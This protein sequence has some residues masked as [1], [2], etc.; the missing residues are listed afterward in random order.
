MI[1]IASNES[2]RTLRYHAL[3]FAV[4]F[5]PISA[6]ALCIFGL[7]TLPLGTVCFTLPLILIGVLIADRNPE[8][9]RNAAKG[10]CCGVIA[11][12]IYDL[13][14]W[15]LSAHLG[16]VDFIREHP[17]FPV[18]AGAALVLAR[19]FRPPGSP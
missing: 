1:S 15:T 4:G 12:L 14:R 16:L 9:A 6:L 8:A 18:A 3:Y 5:A 19:A 7:W 2:D 11:V 13:A 10:F 17:S